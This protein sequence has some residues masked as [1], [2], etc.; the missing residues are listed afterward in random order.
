MKVDS[1][2]FLSKK[3]TAYYEVEGKES[4]VRVSLQNVKSDATADQLVE[5]VNAINDLHAGTFVDLQITDV[6]RVFT[7]EAA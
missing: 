1:V 4:Q 6:N 2:E 5:V 3:M 7:S